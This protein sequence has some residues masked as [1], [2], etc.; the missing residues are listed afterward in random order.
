MRKIFSV[1]AIIVAAVFLLAPAAG[2][3][4]AQDDDCDIYVTP[5]ISAG[6]SVTQGASL[7]VSGSGFAGGATIT[8]SING[9]AVGTT[10]A[11]AGGSFSTSVTVPASTP[12]GPA[13]VVAS[14]DSCNH[15]ASTTTEILSAGGTTSTNVGGTSA[16]AKPTAAVATTSSTLPRTGSNTGSLVAVAVGLTG[17]GAVALLAARRRSADIT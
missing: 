11:T 9:T 10:T 13:S 12:V 7:T 16:T 5:V 6:G 3:G 17:L 8:I 15:S 2:A 14:S 4:T 1:V